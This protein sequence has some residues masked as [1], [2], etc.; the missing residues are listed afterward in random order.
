MYAKVEQ[1]CHCGYKPTR[2]FG[3]SWSYST[4]SLKT[5]LSWFKLTTDGRKEVLYERFFGAKLYHEEYMRQLRGEH[6]DQDTSREVVSDSEEESNPNK[7]DGSAE[8]EWVQCDQC[9]KWRSLPK[10]ISPESLPDEWNC[11]LN[12]WNEQYNS[13]E[14]DE[15]PQPDDNEES[16]E[17]DEDA[18]EYVQ[19][20][21]PEYKRR[22]LA[23]FKEYYSELQAK[24]KQREEDIEEQK[25]ERALKKQRRVE[26]GIREYM[27]SLSE[28]DQKVALKAAVKKNGKGQIPMH[29]YPQKYAD[30]RAT[31]LLRQDL[32]LLRASDT[33]RPQIADLVNMGDK[34]GRTPM[35]YAVLNED[36]DSYR[37]EL[38][39]AGGSMYCCD[40]YEKCPEEYMP[41]F[42]DKKTWI[43][44][45]I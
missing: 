32:A 22:I 40:M 4:E 36:H 25:Q 15:E 20:K 3:D 14:K 18:E 12:T 38:E 37:E 43:D 24:R 19:W 33:Y 1:W 2:D 8:Q 34:Y 39:K 26:D 10:D 27:E 17:C 29:W 44:K 23:D 35:H 21:D 28:D 11:T 9:S 16:E 13:C 5:Y 31:T 45:F 6:E 42:K 30:T 41:L 7:D